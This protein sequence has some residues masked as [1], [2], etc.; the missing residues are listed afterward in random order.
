MIKLKASIIEI[1]GEISLLLQIGE[2]AAEVIHACLKLARIII[3]RNP[4]PV[5]PIEARRN[6]AEE[7]ADLNLVT[8]EWLMFQPSNT[9][10][11]MNN[12][13]DTKLE[14]WKKR[15]AEAY[16]EMVEDEDER[17]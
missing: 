17:K 7:L 3:G 10:E 4:T 9:A 13:I 2:E 11:F 8:H 5:R 6:L 14:R 16:P 1:I 15:L 12:T